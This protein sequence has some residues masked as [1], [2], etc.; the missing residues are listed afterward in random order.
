[1]AEF[2]LIGGKAFGGSKRM[3]RA[4]YLAGD[5]SPIEAASARECL[6]C[7]AILTTTCAPAWRAGQSTD[8]CMDHQML[9]PQ[10]HDE[11]RTIVMLSTARV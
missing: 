6:C 9:S 7:P 8:S 2:P 3:W 5:D 1:M 11:S 10:D 4:R